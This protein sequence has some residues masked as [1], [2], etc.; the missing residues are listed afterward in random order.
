M[1]EIKNIH[2]LVKNKVLLS[3]ISARFELGKITGIIGSNGAGK[4]TLL[5][6][7]SGENKASNGKVYLLGNEITN[8]Y[9]D[10]PAHMRAVVAQSEMVIADITVIEYVLL[11]CLVFSVSG[12]YTIKDYKKVERALEFTGS[13]NLSNMNLSSLSGGEKQRVQLARALVQLEDK[14]CQ[15]SGYLFLDEF[16][17]SMDVYFQKKMLEL[18]RVLVENQKLAIIIIAHDLGQ[19][20]NYFDCCLLLKNGSIVSFGTPIEVL[21]N[22]NIKNAY[23]IDVNK[24]E[25]DGKYYFTY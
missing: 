4:S 24:I 13:S 19:I 15:Y 16:S 2:Y 17:A 22:E 1:L 25:V 23:N 14:D 7:I 8:N 21:T 11:G 3:D 5:K 9:A 6:I 20:M 10:F 12:Q 18:L